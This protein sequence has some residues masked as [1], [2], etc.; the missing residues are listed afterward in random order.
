[1]LAAA[2][3]L[4]LAALL[5][6]PREGTAQSA[7]QDSL[8]TAGL[9]RS[10]GYVGA[11]A[12]PETSL[13]TCLGIPGSR[14]ANW[15]PSGSGG[16]PGGATVATDGQNVYFVGTQGALSCP[17]ADLGTN[18]TR[19]MAGPWPSNSGL[20]SATAIA[21]YGGEIWI[22]QASGEIYRCPADLPYVAQNTAPSECTLLDDAG[23]RGVYSLLLAN[24]TLYAGLAMAS[25]SEYGI[26]YSKGLIWSCP[27]QVANACTNLDNPGNTLPA[28]LAGGGGYLWVGLEN[29]IVWR[30]DPDTANACTDWERA[31][32]TVESLSYDGQGTLYAA[33]TGSNGVIWSCPTAAANGCSTVRSNVSGVSVAAGAGGVFSSS[34]RNPGF[35]FNASPLTAAN[36]SGSS[37]WSYSPLLYLPAGGPVGVGAAAVG[38]SLAAPATDADAAGQQCGHGGKRAK[39]TVTLTGP[40]GYEKTQ[41]MRLCKLLE[42]PAHFSLLDP[43]DYRAMVQTRGG[44]G[45]AR[46]TVEQDRTRPVDVR[47]EWVPRTQPTTGSAAAGR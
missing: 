19:I 2:L 30:C 22:G 4:P 7:P 10:T 8:W 40:H 28:S 13:A 36:A 5:E 27:S 18:C 41:R 43:G 26:S 42:A 6:A 34:G 14:I 23:N 3:L 37:Y 32:N 16:A 44:V 35:F 39:A 21:A 25:R 11:C 17:V 47:L 38:V 15:S 9:S 24:G 45:E 12:S 1:V 29:G 33:V 20:N 31:G 46:F